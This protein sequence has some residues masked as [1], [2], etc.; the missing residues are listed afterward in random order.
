MNRLDFEVKRSKVKVTARS[1]KL[2]DRHFLTYLQNSWT[3]F[4][5]TY[6]SYSTCSP[7]DTSDIFKII[8]SEV[9][10]DSNIF[11]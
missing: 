11:Q 8:G 6:R 3:Y 1:Y 2:F 10:I 7:H 4:N 5:E 9:N